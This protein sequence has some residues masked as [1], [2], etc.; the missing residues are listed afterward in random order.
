MLLPTVKGTG[1]RLRESFLHDPPSFHEEHPHPVDDV[2]PA[3][4]PLVY[5]IIFS[6][7][8]RHIIH[9]LV[10]NRHTNYSH[11]LESDIHESVISMMESKCKGIKKT[12]ESL[13]T[14][15]NG[16]RIFCLKGSTK[17]LGCCCLRVPLKPQLTYRA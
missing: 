6:L 11:I 13:M 2:C 1:L 5:I 12:M 4:L 3:D 14:T 15:N 7:Y 9:Q 16:Q 17:K 8:A 10:I